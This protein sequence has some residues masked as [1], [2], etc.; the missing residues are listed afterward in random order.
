VSPPAGSGS[1]AVQV[2]AAANTNGPARAGTLLIAGQVVTVNQAAPTP[3]DLVPAP[4]SVSSGGPMYCDFDPALGTVVRA[5]TRNVGLGP[6]TVPSF[7]TLF[8][9]NTEQTLSQPVPA[10]L[11]PTGQVLSTF[12]LPDNCGSCQWRLTV[13]GTNIVY[14]GATGAD[15]NNFVD[16]TC[17]VSSPTGAA[18]QVRTVIGRH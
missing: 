13:D 12:D 9:R 8:V 5:Y 18:R 1:I 16:G 4:L 7:T 15:T 6:A 3:P 11:N 17:F 14:E 2:T 10:P